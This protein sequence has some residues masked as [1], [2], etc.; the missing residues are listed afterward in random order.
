MYTISVALGFLPVGCPS[1]TSGS[2]ILP[3]ERCPAEPKALPRLYII[4]RVQ[5]P[6]D[7]QYGI[8]NEKWDWP[9]SQTKDGSL[10]FPDAPYIHDCRLLRR[11]STGTPG[12]SLSSDAMKRIKKATTLNISHRRKPHRKTAAEEN[13]VRPTETESERRT[14]H[15]VDEH[16]ADDAH[17]SDFEEEYSVSVEPSDEDAG[18]SPDD[19]LGLYLRQMGAIPLLNR[20]EEL[21]LAQRLETAR[22]RY[23]HAALLNWPVIR[24]VVETFDRVRAGE[25]AIDPT[26]D[27]VTSL[28]LSRE[29][30]QARMP[31]N[32]K[33]LRSL[34]YKGEH[35]FR[36]LLRAAY[37][38][39]WR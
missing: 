26:I 1:A 39:Q 15:P 10:L 14:T 4:K 13:H 34:I 31:Y 24:R 21:D 28:G 18:Q 7:G 8:G 38:G 35:D 5:G 37:K 27:V 20:K 6:E 32:L 33:T 23:R 12:C 9:K 17:D 2:Y 11:E 3:P 22:R 29:K 19:T 30:I 36:L 25:L 16:F